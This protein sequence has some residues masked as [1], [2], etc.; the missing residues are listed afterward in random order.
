M[1]LPAPSVAAILSV[2]LNAGI[3]FGHSAT[4]PAPRPDDWWKARH[5]LINSNVAAAGA[6][7]Q[8]VFVGDSITQ[9]WEGAGKA[10]WEHYYARRHALNLGIGGDRTQHV[11]WRLDHGALDG[12]KPKAAVVMIGTNNSNGE[13]NT[14][15][16]IADGA[17]AVVARLRAALPDARVLLCAIFPRGENTNPQRGKILQA[18]QILRR[19]A[20][21]TNVVW[22]DFGHLFIDDH[23][24]IPGAL[25]PDFLHPAEPGYRLWAEALEDRLAQMIGDPRVSPMPAAGIGGEWVLTL[26]GPDGRP[27]SFAMTLREEGGRLN[28]RV[29]RDASRWMDLLDGATDGAQ[30]SWVLKR[31]RPD[32]STMEYRMSGRLEGGGLKGQ[33]KALLDGREVVSDWSAQRK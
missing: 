32:G 9:G 1:H 16:Q 23:G 2:W 15:D 25:M 22:V 3:A 31:D 28:G 7:A 17:A 33:A 21:G 12:L 24:L 13:D 18:N 6:Q 5:S 14:A 30:F 20:D 10:V 19:V 27:R 29:Q 4:E 11:L 26:N 8:I